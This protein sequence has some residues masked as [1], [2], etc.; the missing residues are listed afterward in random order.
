MDWFSGGYLSRCDFCDRSKTKTIPK[1]PTKSCLTLILQNYPK[2]RNCQKE[3][4]YFFVLEKLTFIYIDLFSKID[5]LTLL[6]KF[7]VCR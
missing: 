7:P 4:T 1:V 5:L 3:L 2:S 6:E